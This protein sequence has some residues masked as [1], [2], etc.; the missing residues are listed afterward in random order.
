MASQTL[1][2]SAH[3][4][5]FL[6]PSQGKV[7]LDA[8]NLTLM[9]EEEAHASLKNWSFKNADRLAKKRRSD[10]LEQPL[11]EKAGEGSSGRSDSQTLMMLLRYSAADTPLLLVAFSAGKSLWCL[12]IL[13][14][15]IN[16]CSPKNIAPK[17]CAKLDLRNVFAFPILHKDSAWLPIFDSR[18]VLL[19]L[20]LG[21]RYI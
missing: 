18:V 21:R 3:N 6:L 16:P 17:P 8:L 4:S 5:L 1:H 10:D 12:E 13:L 11:L 14:A 19:P 15:D 2:F 20:S 7:Y 9:E